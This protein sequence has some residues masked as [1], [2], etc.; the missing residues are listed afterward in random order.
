MSMQEATLEVAT[1]PGTIIKVIK[2]PA[3]PPVSFFGIFTLLEAAPDRYAVVVELDLQV[4]QTVIR[5]RFP[6]PKSLATLADWPDPKPI[7]PPRL[8]KSIG[9]DPPAWMLQVGTR[10][11][12]EFPWR[13]F[14]APIYS[15]ASQ[16]FSIRDMKLSPAD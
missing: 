7:Y 12:A 13:S 14:R 8:E 10:V 15:G 9:A 16:P 4:A 6:P 1:I 3:R 5:K 11:N 2:T